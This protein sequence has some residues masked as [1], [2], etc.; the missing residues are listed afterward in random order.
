MALNDLIERFR[1]LRQHPVYQQHRAL[2][3]LRA[4]AWS[5]HCLLGIPAHATFRRWNYRLYLPP[6][7]RG[8]GCTSPF[9]FR[10]H[11]EPELMLLERY[12]QPGMVFIDGGANT[13]VF[14]FTAA[15]L[16]GPTGRVLAF[17][18]GSACSAALR[19]SQALN[20]WP[21]VTIHQQA[22]SDCN[23]TARL[24]HNMN[25][26]NAFSLGSD[27]NSS[28]DEVEVTTIDEMAR[29]EHLQRVDF[30]KLDVEGAEELV[31][32]G[33]GDVLRKWRPIILFEINLKAIK[34]LKLNADGA[35]RLLEGQGY[36]LFQSDDEGSLNPLSHLPDGVGNL[37]ALPE[38]RVVTEQALQ[39]NV[40]KLASGSHFVAAS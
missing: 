1:K 20:Q 12:L 32:C 15:R 38:E 29:A 11:Y 40:G 10:E 21:Q 34:L 36:R 17:E 22:L 4:G 37:L 39:K 31:L 3:L 13:G 19:R 2:V 24:Y 18:P 30:I 6:K 28:F 8:G 9:V 23:G 16:V 25:Q 14:T 26:E 35:C 5:V 27:E 7:W 33:S